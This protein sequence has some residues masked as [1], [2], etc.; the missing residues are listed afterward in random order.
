MVTRHLTLEETAKLMGSTVKAL[1]NR[2]ARGHLPYR[3]LG[4]RVLIPADELEKFFATLPGRSAAE[5]LATV[6]E[7]R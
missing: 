6:E 5:A 7:G 1:R 4:R 2:I 3:K